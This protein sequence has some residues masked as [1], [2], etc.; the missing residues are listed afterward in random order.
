MYH[1][2]EKKMEV[3]IVI[4]KQ[5]NLLTLVQYWYITLYQ[6]FMKQNHAVTALIIINISQLAI[7]CI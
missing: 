7:S 2:S 1:D 3:Q 4:H 5:F 6:N